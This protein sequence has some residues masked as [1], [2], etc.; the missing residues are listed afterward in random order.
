MKIFVAIGVRRPGVP[1]V[2]LTAIPG[3]M[4]G[5]REWS[6]AAN[7]KHNWVAGVVPL[8][9]VIRELAKKV[10]FAVSTV[11]AAGIQRTM[12]DALPT[13]LPGATHI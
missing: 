4:S 3:K 7:G 2:C 13:V 1:N 11:I 9:G 5:L 12:T 10:R 8:G 6:V